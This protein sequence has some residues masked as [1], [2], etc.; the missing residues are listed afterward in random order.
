MADLMGK[1]DSLLQK[2]KTENMLNR[3]PKEAKEWAESL[4]WNERRYLLSLC[5]LLCAT[6]TEVQ[7]EFLD[8]YT[9]DG[10]V[11]KIWLDPD[12]QTKVQTYL[13]KFH[14]D[15][16][17]NESLIR[18]YIR[19]FYI[20]SAQDVR[21][22]PDQY[23]ES[24]LRLVT[25]FEQKNYLLYYILGFELLKMMFS[26]SWLQQERLYRLQIHQEEFIQT[27]VKPIRYAHR[28]N[29]I[30]VPVDEKVFFSRRNYFVKKPDI[31]EKKLLE[32]ICLTFT[33]DAVSHLGFSLNRN[34][35][36]I[37][38]DYNHIFQDEQEGLF[39]G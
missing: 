19:L 22:K 3:L 30:I 16:E 27:Y 14:I 20:H 18:K 29:G 25:S 2:N 10:V 17:L 32:L 7:A 13:N 12:T 6:P 39:P 4:P 21:R 5:H 11:S 28:I 38:F 33:T 36:H 24:A 35:E 8:E 34:S 37:V 26:M 15:T 1:I 23:L 31:R 9:A